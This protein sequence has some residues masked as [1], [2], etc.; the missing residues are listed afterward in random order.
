VVNSVTLKPGNNIP[1]VVNQV[2][3]IDA[4]SVET[5]P[6][7]FSLWLTWLGQW[8]CSWMFHSP[9]EQSNIH[10]HST[11]KQYTNIHTHLPTCAQTLVLVL[12]FL[13]VLVFAKRDRCAY[14][15]GVRLHSHSYVY[16]YS[17]Q[18]RLLVQASLI[19]VEH[20]RT[21]VQ[22]QILII[23]SQL[24]IWWKLWNILNFF[25]QMLT[26]LSTAM[27]YIAVYITIAPYLSAVSKSNTTCLLVRVA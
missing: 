19:W 27:L 13:P 15:S 23:Q 20:S 18:Y 25:L 9:A 17:S 4:Q 24:K 2:D 8:H 14:F 3:W 7:C 1:W 11:Q 21:L 26:P 5:S 6:W 22:A 10:V 12:L 16:Q